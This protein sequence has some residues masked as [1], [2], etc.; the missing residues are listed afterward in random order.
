MRTNLLKIF[1]FLSGLFSISGCDNTVDVN[2]DWQE[3]MVVYGLL[4]PTDDVNY[5]RITKAFLNPEGNAVQI[6]GISD[7]LYFDSLEV[8]IQEFKNGNP[9]NVM[10]L[11]LVDGNLIGIP[12]DSGLFASDVNYLYRLNDKIKSDSKYKL[13]VFNKKSGRIV[14][15]ETDIVKAIKPQDI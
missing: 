11:E 4:N 13:Q 14:T 5:I 3:I 7:S 15:A 6:A 2:A 8:V 10:T 1:A 9:I 12:K